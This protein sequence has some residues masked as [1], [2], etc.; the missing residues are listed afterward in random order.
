MCIVDCIV[1]GDGP[2]TRLVGAMLLA[3]NDEWSLN[4]R[5]M[6]RRYMQ[7]EGLHSLSDTAA[8]RVPAVQR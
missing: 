4:R 3:Q 6:Q 7:L 2:I 1:T 8:A 5:Y